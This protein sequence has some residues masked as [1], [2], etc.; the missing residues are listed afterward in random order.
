[1]AQEIKTNTAISLCVGP[2]FDKTDGVTPETALTVANCKITLIAETDDNNAPTLILDNV[3]GNDGTN[4]LAH[5]TNDDAG[6][7]SLLLTAANLNRLGRMKLAIEDAANHCPVFHELEIVSA[8]YYSN[9]YG[10]TIETVN[11][12]QISGDATAADNAESFFDGTGYAG[13]NNVIPT[14]TTLTGHTAQ[15][16][17]AYAIVNNGTYGNS[18]IKGYVDDIGVAGAGLT[19]IP[20]NAAWDAEVESECTDALVANN[21]DHL[22]KTATAAADMTTEVTDGTVISRMLSKTSDTSTYDVTTDS[23]EAVRDRGDAAWITATGFSTHSAADVKTAIEA[24]GSSLALILED[25]GT[26]IPSLI[27]ALNN[28]AVS[29]ILAGVV[30]GTI[31]VKQ[32]LQ[33]TIAFA[34]GLASGGGTAT[35]KFRDQADTKDRITM[36]VDANGNRTVV[37]TS[38]D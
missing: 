15:T 22:C 2:F 21:L 8:N 19:A 12:T 16:G 13:T 37:T 32:A 29:D 33:A 5:I 18:A 3:A 6:Y 9:K 1:M 27:A 7:Y 28:V 31:T 14:V 36:T 34:A 24:A 38:F 35:L 10:S 23:L 4:T 11:V 20:W 26:T 17:D 30:E 25:T